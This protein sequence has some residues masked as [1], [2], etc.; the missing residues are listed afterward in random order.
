MDVSRL[1]RK[2]TVVRSSTTKL[3]NDIT[4]KRD[5]A[6]I[7]ELESNLDLL[8]LKE[9]SLKELDEEIHTVIEVEELEDD[10]ASAES[11]A[12]KIIVAKSEVRSWIKDLKSGNEKAAATAA[13]R[14]TDPRQQAE[15]S[16]TPVPPVQVVR[17]PKLEISK[18]GGE[19]RKWQGFWSQFNSTIHSNPT[20]SKI[21]K[22]KYLNSYMTAKAAAA[23]AGLDLSEAN[24]D[25]ALTILQERF[26]RKEMII[27]EHM[28]RLLHVKPVQ[29]VRN[30]DKLRGLVDEV[31]TEVRSLA[32]LGVSASTYGVLLLT[33][34]KKAVPADLCLEYYRRHDETKEGSEV[35]TFLLFLRKEVET[36]EK[37]QAADSRHREPTAAPNRHKSGFK[38]SH[39]PSAALLNAVTDKDSTGCVFCRSSNHDAGSCDS[40]MSVSEKRELLKRDN[41][42]FR[43]T[44][45]GHRSKECRTA[46][47]LKCASCGG[48]HLTTLCDPNM[49]GADNTAKENATVTT[50]TEPKTVLQSSLDARNHGS[51]VFLQTAKAWAEGQQKRTLV[52][53][54]L[55]GGSQR[56]FI[57]SDLSKNLQLKVLGEEELNIFTFGGAEAAR[58][59]KSRRVELWLRS[60]HDRTEVRVEALEVPCIC[61]DLMP[62]PSDA[63]VLR[64]LEEGMKVAD[65]SHGD[66]SDE[67]IGL[68][69]G[70]DFYWAVVTGSVRRLAPKLMAVDTAFGWTLQGEV[71]TTRS[72]AICST[73]T[74]V[75]RASVSEE[76]D[77]DIA[78]QLRSFWELEHLGINETERVCPEDAVLQ[79][80][81][82]TV[83]FEDGRYKVSF[84][85]KPTATE[86]SDN[87]ECAAR[88]LKSLTTR[89]SKSEHLMQEYDTSIRDYIKKGFA[90]EVK[91]NKDSTSPLYYMPHQAVVR[92]DSQT[93]KLRVVF[94]ASSST[95]NRPSLND[96]L[97]SGP[98]LN[99]ELIDVLTRFRT[100]NIAIV[101]DIEKAFLQISLAKTDRSAVRFL[102]YERTPKIGEELPPVVTY[103]MTRVPFGV[104]SS[105]FLLAATLH[106]HLRN[107]PE[108]YD[109]T[110]DILRSHLYVDDLVTGVDSREQATK[111]C[112]EATTIMGQAGMK[113]HKWMSNDAELL[114]SLEQGAV[115][116]QYNDFGHAA[117][118]KVLGVG[119]NPQSD[120]FE[121][122]LTALIDFLSARVDNKRFVLQVSARIFDP[123]GFLSP[124][125]VNVK[126]MFQRL[127]ELG[128]KWDEPL[129]SSLQTEW[130]Q[131]C[132][133]LP[134]IQQITVPRMIAA[135]FGDDQTKKV[136]HVFCDASPKAYGAVAYIVTTSAAGE[137]GVSLIMARTRVAPLKRLSLPRL[138]L[139]G[140]LI[141]ARLCQCL[142]KTLRMEHARVRLWTDST[143]AMYWIKGSASRWKP[144]VANR[145]TELQTLT[146][147]EDWGHCPGADNPADLLTRGIL[148]S[149]LVQSA[150]WWRGPQWLL[151]DESGWPM[152]GNQASQQADSYKEEMRVAA[153]PVMSPSQ[154]PIL[155][156]KDHS[157]FNRI[158]RVTAWVLRFVDN[159]R[160]K[161]E[162]RKGSLT[163][164]EII[165][166]EKYW[167]ATIQKEAFG[168]DISNL[169]TQRPLSKKSPVYLFNPY[170]DEDG[171]M[172]VGGRL[173]FSQNS[174]STKHPI[175]LPGDHPFTSLLIQREHLRLLHSGVRDTLAQ[176]RESYWI[177]RGRQVVKKVVNQCLKC[178]KQSCPPASEQVAPL[179]ADRVTQGNPF[180]VVGVDFAGPLMCRESGGTKKC[181]IALFTCAVT[182]A[183]HLELVSDLSAAAF[184]L[185][186]KRFVA[187]RGMCTT[188]YSDNALTFKRSSRDLKL[189]F[190]SL[191]SEETLSYFADHR[192]RW[193]YIVERAAWW[194]GFWERLV[195][196][197][198]VSLRKVL[199]R[200]SLN[201]E[202]LTTILNEVEAVINSR[203]LTFVYSEA[204]EPE[205]LSPGHFL[206]GRKL[207]ALPPHRLPAATSPGGQQLVRRWRYRSTIADNF[208]RRWR[209]EYLL[210][211]RSAHLSKP[212]VS[213]GLQAG[214]LVL[215]KEDHLKRHLWK[216]GRITETFKGRD[217]LVRSCKLRLP[218][219]A[220]VR[221]PIQLLYPLE[222]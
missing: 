50:V 102:W 98:N 70:A 67:G 156:L 104:T 73:A 22:F 198:K 68:L 215:L 34:L 55:D 12:E 95:N 200:S 27:E 7:G 171:L 123:F 158:L 166:S 60:Q 18:F 183:V 23:I 11:Y 205:P 220:E 153:M 79:H 51:Q 145:V 56:T 76:T 213:S 106:H 36:R 96:V 201:F 150:L 187:R 197:V 208:W 37:I 170:I 107:L 4:D 126:M 155:N 178:R 116:Q 217:G 169:L 84:P 189:M 132:S 214:D 100:H 135:D 40:R 72:T 41:R 199:G 10:V 69:I 21:D 66:H 124:T 138:E 159:T 103:Q 8:S 188:V 172:R 47:W 113:L 48:K 62:V 149:A 16:M 130:D 173:H 143:V 2:R 19:L 168:D 202:E 120:V 114:N 38:G 57:R 131:W 74:S 121:Y 13:T 91:E 71:G 3:I 112:Q 99:P 160:K 207:T 65:V 26:G 101:A 63:D 179:P 31:Q 59:T 137:V 127:W 129:P 20:L 186:F 174:E 148:P 108:Q 118:A 25:V 216:T 30:L 161:D 184:L 39:A 191:Q 43:C 162:K 176:L 53:L 9:R 97:E 195:R 210:E 77:K 28:S 82:E 94:D 115:Q 167:L 32:A 111:L 64:M 221:R 61:A 87:Q 45:K 54:L 81:K 151:N 17:L 193:K 24:Y 203:P 144:F 44:R 196:S 6:S 157:S 175:V 83:R 154:D 222:P 177:L 139:M 35:E 218:G 134:L 194:G 93:T 182:R 110:A 42:C 85:W 89:L 136:L 180:D 86:L 128:V 140:A 152:L 5:S 209:K 117:A 192:I 142:V 133:E 52:R 165:T 185:A 125:T 105:P 146:N 164:E 46:R 29:D 190:D 49:S 75:M 33:V 119:W 92:H 14:Q 109:G 219:G 141:G 163:A 211:L 58:H 122:R 147:P 90:E 181:Y 80:H 212:T 78:S 206:V 204:D 1:K 15:T 88:R